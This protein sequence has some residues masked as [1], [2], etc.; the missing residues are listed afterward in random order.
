MAG[1]RVVLDVLVENA[2]G[3]AFWQEA[4]FRPYATMMEL[5]R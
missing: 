4:G 5:S 2:A 1:E 3:Q